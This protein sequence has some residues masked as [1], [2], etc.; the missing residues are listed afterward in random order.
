MP[1]LLRVSDLQRRI[2]AAAQA[3]GSEPTFPQLELHQLLPHLRLQHTVEPRP[4]FAPR[5]R[6]ERVW[7]RINTIVRRFA[8]HAIEPAVTQQNEFN[9]ALLHALEQMIAA[10]A[11][12]RAAISVERGKL[13]DRREAHNE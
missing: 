4:A 2:E 3:A 5:T 13:I 12:L 7:A 1:E 6:Y 8:A 11:T 10:D 9:A